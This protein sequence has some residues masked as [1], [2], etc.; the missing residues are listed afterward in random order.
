MEHLLS[1]N[2]DRPKT[3]RSTYIVNINSSNNNNNTNSYGLNKNKYLSTTF[4]NMPVLKIK[5]SNT[6]IT[7]Y[8][9]KNEPVLKPKT[10]MISNLIGN[11]V[12]HTTNKI[13]NTG[14]K[15]C[16][17]TDFFPT[18]T[19]HIDKGS[20]SSSSKT[21][22]PASFSSIS[23]SSSSSSASC[24]MKSSSQLL[25]NLIDSKT[26]ST[27]YSTCKSINQNFDPKNTQLIIT[28]NNNE[29]SYKPVEIVKNSDRK[30]KKYLSVTN[31]YLM[32]K[33][34]KINTIIDMPSSASSSLIFSSNKINISVNNNYEASSNKSTSSASTESSIGSSSA[35]TLSS[36]SLSIRTLKNTKSK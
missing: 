11:R 22:T 36:S 9:C 2:S 12:I 1:N 26:T 33:I 4:L 35:S 5:Q 16:R 20:T 3:M 10:E 17:L 18:K 14:F 24:S 31:M 21:T 27:V 7:D 15:N 25:V 8:Y 29:T 19:K 23:S 6:E 28:K 30:T 34:N 13:S 32:G